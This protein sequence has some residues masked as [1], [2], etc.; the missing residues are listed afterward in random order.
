MSNKDTEKKARFEDTYVEQ[1]NNP[2]IRNADNEGLGQLRGGKIVI[3]HVDEVN[4]RDAQEVPGFVATR[5]ELIQLAKYW[6]KRAVD[7]EYFWFCCEQVGSSD[8]RIRTFAWN[9]VD[10]IADLLGEDEVNQAVQQA[11]DEYGKEQ[12]P[13]V[14]SIFRNGTPEEQ[15]AFHEETRRHFEENAPEICDDSNS[16]SDETAEE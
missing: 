16:T 8:R 13:K 14:W 6:T 11:I 9:R 10:R 7:I 12:D 4:G 5:H 2:I 15:K 3:G 1:L